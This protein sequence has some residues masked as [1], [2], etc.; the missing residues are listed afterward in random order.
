MNRTSPAAVAAVML[1][2]S[3]AGSVAAGPLEDGL[4][5]RKNS[6]YEAAIR[7]LRPLADQGDAQAQY[8]VGE[9]YQYGQGVPHDNA[10]AMNWYQKAAAQGYARAQHHI[11]FM[12]HFGQGDAQQAALLDA[13]HHRL[14]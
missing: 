13:V 12:Y 3:F 6:D 14:G 2:V 8:N 7:L 9:M 11:G 5:A 4:V 1:A 10:I